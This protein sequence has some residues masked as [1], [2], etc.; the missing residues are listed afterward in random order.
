MVFERTGVPFIDDAAAHGNAGAVHAIGIARYKWVPVWQVLPVIEPSIRA[1][2]WQPIYVGQGFGCQADA[3]GYAAAPVCVVCA[4]ARL[5]VEQAAR[6]VCPGNLAG[7]VIAQFVQAAPAAPVAQ[8]LPFGARHFREGFGLPERLC[9][10]GHLD[11]E[12]FLF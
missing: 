11:K 12:V 6:H 5:S 7:V 8:R 3:I 4:L 2:W 9:G 10:Y 1:G